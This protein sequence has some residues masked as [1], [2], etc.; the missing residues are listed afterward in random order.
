VCSKCEVTETGIC[1]CGTSMDPEGRT[2]TC[3]VKG[4]SG[5]C[6]VCRHSA[7][8]E[9]VDTSHLGSDFQEF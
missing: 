5:Y 2:D 6:D 7:G 9:P 4:P 3:G 1:F 8:Y